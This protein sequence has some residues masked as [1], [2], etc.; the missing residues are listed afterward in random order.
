M[1]LCTGESTAR[2]AKPLVARWMTGG[3]PIEADECAVEAPF[4]LALSMVV[5]ECAVEVP[6]SLALFKCVDVR[7]VEVSFPPA[8]LMYVPSQADVDECTVE[9]PFSLVPSVSEAWTSGAS[10]Y[11][12]GSRTEVATPSWTRLTFDSLF[13]GDDC[14]MEESVMET[15]VEETSAS[16]T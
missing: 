6:F 16:P 5:D 9:V 1:P 10:V 15:S 8:L 7:A 2:V 13:D 14:M 3:V 4:S 11:V 12:D